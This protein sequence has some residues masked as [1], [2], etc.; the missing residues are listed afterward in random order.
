MT[1]W[2]AT[3]IGEPW[4]A[5]ENDCWA[6]CRRVW[7][8]RYGVTV[9]IIGVDTENMLAVAHAFR[10][11]D[12]RTH[13]HEVDVPREGDA[14]LMAHWR[15]PSH[16]GIWI[17]ADGGGVLH[18]EKGAGVIFNSRS[19]LFAAGWKDLRYYRRMTKS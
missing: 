3:Y 8:E 15:H 11:N 12:E 16:V 18:C 9:P 1:H 17:D 10:E 4:V 6:F 14:V 13:W 19:A 7:S 5:Q 2:A